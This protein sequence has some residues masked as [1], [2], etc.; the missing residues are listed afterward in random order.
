M[1]TQP[2]DLKG[3]NSIILITSQY[4]RTFFGGKEGGKRKLEIG[5][6]WSN[7]CASAHLNPLSGSGIIGGILWGRG[8][9]EVTDHR[10]MTVHGVIRE[11]GS[12]FF[13]SIYK[14]LALGLE[15]EEPERAPR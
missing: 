7:L 3:M 9:K 13:L 5:V 4:L 15:G 6:D 11:I 8:R 10:G 12:F 14:R 1:S 2:P